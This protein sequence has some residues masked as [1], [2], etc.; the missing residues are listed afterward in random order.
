[1]L[2]SLCVC[3]WGKEEE[4]AKAD[5]LSFTAACVAHTHAPTH[6]YAQEKN[7]QKKKAGR[8]RSSYVCVCGGRGQLASLPVCIREE[9]KEV[10]KLEDRRKY[11]R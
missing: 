5:E 2:V 6:T 8:Y 9:E 10:G 3:L 1:V 7:Q 11:I 4:R